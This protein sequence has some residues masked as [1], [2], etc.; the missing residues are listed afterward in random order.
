[1]EL[2]QETIERFYNN[3]GKILYMTSKTQTAK[4]KSRQVGHQSKKLLCGKRN[5]RVRG[6]LQNRRKYL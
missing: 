3:I 4:A 6:S 2:I 1:M 5:R